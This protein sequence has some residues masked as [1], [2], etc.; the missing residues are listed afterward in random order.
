MLKLRYD[1]TLKNGV[2]EKELIDEIRVRNG[3]LKLCIHRTKDE[4]I[5]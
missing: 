5:L 3:N 1:I 4:E 2:K